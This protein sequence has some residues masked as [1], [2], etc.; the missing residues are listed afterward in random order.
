MEMKHHPQRVRLP[1]QSNT[2][3]PDVVR[4]DDRTLNRAL[5]TEAASPRCALWSELGSQ[6]SGS[7]DADVQLPSGDEAEPL[8][9][10]D[11]LGVVGPHV[12]EGNLVPGGDLLDQLGD[13]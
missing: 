3:R 10:P 6:R 9:D 1:Y 5:Q 8:V 11:R 13:Q 12:Q 2:A 7:D 4:L